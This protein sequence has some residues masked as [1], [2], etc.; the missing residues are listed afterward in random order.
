MDEESILAIRDAV[1]RLRKEIEKLTNAVLTLA[2]IATSSRASGDIPSRE[3]REAV[4]AIYN[5]IE[6][7]V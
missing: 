2:V 7:R 1:N 3:A 4:Y 5:N 6:G